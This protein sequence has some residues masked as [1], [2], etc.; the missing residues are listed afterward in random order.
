MYFVRDVVIYVFRVCV[1][2]F[3]GLFVVSFVIS[4]VRYFVRVLFV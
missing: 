1:S 3:I 2:L 4:F